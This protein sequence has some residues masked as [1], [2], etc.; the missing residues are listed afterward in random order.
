MPLRFPKLDRPSMPGLKSGEKI[1]E[2]AIATERLMDGDV[3]Y[4]VYGDR[5]KRRRVARVVPQEGLEPPTRALRM[6][7][8]TS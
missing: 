5:Y 3:R 1:M 6:R 8:S 7:C 4:S 2:H